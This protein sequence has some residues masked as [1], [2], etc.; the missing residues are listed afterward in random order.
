MQQSWFWTTKGDRTSDSIEVPS[1]D[2]KVVLP[3]LSHLNGR[4]AVNCLLYLK[5][6]NLVHD[7]T[8]DSVDVVPK[9]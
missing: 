4:V 3:R 9:A 1:V 2:G 5:A 6:F 8:G 7:E